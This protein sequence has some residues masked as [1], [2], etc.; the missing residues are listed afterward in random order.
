MNMLEKNMAA[1]DERYPALAAAVQGERALSYTL[2]PSRDPRLPNLLHHGGTESMLFY[3]PQDPLGHTRSV[4][5]ALE[6]ESASLL[7]VLGL[8]MG[9]P[10]NIL[11]SALRG[12]G[13]LRKIIVVE[14]DVGCLRRAMEVL[15]MSQALSHGQ[16]QW[17][18]GA[19]PEQL[20][21]NLWNAVSPEFGGL[22]A[23]KFVPWPASIRLDDAYYAAA[24]EALKDVARSF[25]GER[26]NDPYDSLV[27]YENFFHN[28]PRYL[29]SPGIRH[30]R[31]LFQGRPA[32]VVAAG[33]SLNKN[34][35]LLRLLEKRAVILS[36][37]ASL[38]VLHEKGM[39]PHFVTTV[40]RTPGTDKF[41]DGVTGLERVVLAAASFSYPDTLDAFAGPHLFMHRRYDFYTAMGIDEDCFDMGGT[42]AHCAFALAR[43][44]GCDP[45][46][47]IG[48]DL[49]FG[50]DG[51]T[52]AKGC[53]FGQ[54]Q[55]YA[56]D[57]EKLEVPANLG[58]TVW[59]C[60]L[61]F[62]L[63]REYERTLSRCDGRAINATE[64]G[65]R[66]GGTTVMTFR[67]AIE[68]HCRDP[69]GPREKALAHL[70]GKR[71]GAGPEALLERLH[72]LIPETEKVLQVA[73]A[74]VERV[75]PVVR[76]VEKV[77]DRIPDTLGET[78]LRTSRE[79]N[80]LADLLMTAP[81][82]S[83]AGECFMSLWVPLLIEW[84]VVT[85][86]FA[87]PT[88]AE[89]YRLRLGEQGFGAM[90]QVC[91]SLREALENG[92]EKVLCLL[93][94]SQTLCP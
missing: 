37:D 8:G 18:V 65:A 79:M 40:E 3:D 88:W 43:H 42:T 66:I 11:F 12:P 73:R 80:K 82:L 76:E 10:L 21:G 39:L 9:Y 55:A 87:D 77:G 5:T 86:R 58:G 23:V 35:H 32:V 67:E 6:L 89:A 25:I 33:P 93:N 75:G 74:I 1:L 56:A 59:T 84:Q 81:L 50:P 27:A 52:H 70:S 92:R 63:L 29:T 94:D 34:V 85:E 68:T 36:A 57:A 14:K 28:L 47:F 26:G 49:A 91:L 61:W 17:V 13:P 38:K 41:F 62:R 64:G 54:R 2:V 30:V 53:A 72:V 90:G 51:V 69:F 44:M 15:D 7:V 16:V 71:S 45:I 24:K 46:I 20:Y 83:A 19:L 22:K 48:Q 78:V 31:D 60:P 4:L